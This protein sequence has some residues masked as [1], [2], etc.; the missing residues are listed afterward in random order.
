M[1]KIL[2]NKNKKLTTKTLT[3]I[4]LALV[5]SIIDYSSILMPSLSN[6][7]KTTQDIQ[8]TAM[9]CIFKLNYLTSTEEVGRVSGLPTIL[10]RTKSLNERYFTNCIKF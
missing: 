10:E 6:T 4:Y 3:T 7:L 5:R 9:K 1:I 8:N 2:A